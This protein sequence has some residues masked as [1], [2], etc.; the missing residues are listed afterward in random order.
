MAT[1]KKAAKKA[2]KHADGTYNRNSTEA[3]TK[4]ELAETIKR[5][6]AIATGK[7]KGVII[8]LEQFKDAKGQEGIHGMSY[9]AGMDP[10]AR[11]Q[12]LLSVSG[13]PAKIFM[14]MGTLM[15][16][17]DEDH[18]HDKDGNCLPKKK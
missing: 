15:G 18:D 2:H 5:A 17:I 14:L 3:P 16:G 7:K 6:E 8:V 4:K 9:W 11:V 1:A 10:K 13:M 12:T